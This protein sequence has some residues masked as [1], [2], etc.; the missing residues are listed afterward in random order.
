MR[1]ARFIM[2]VYRVIAAMPTSFLHFPIFLIAPLR[3]IPPLSCTLI[4]MLQRHNALGFRWLIRLFGCSVLCSGPPQKK[5][6]NEKQK[7][8]LQKHPVLKALRPRGQVQH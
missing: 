1:Q 6:N 3:R 5:R 8:N 7:N 4:P 2:A